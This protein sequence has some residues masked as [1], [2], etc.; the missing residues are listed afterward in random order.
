MDW[1]N[2]KGLAEAIS[3]GIFY[4]RKN[5]KFFYNFGG[6]INVKSKNNSFKKMLL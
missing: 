6:F 5:K 3:K 2:L 1:E 4:S